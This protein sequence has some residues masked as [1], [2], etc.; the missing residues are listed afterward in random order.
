MRFT[1]KKKNYSWLNVWAFGFMWYINNTYKVELSWI[2]KGHRKLLLLFDWPASTG[3]KYLCTVLSIF[4][5]FTP[6]RDSSRQMSKY[7]TDE[8]EPTQK[9]RLQTGL[10]ILSGISGTTT[11]WNPWARSWEPQTGLSGLTRCCFECKHEICWL[12]WTEDFPRSAEK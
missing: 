5:H 8:R 1:E 4:S 9:S 11:W 2:Y 6:L 10:S 3:G 7:Q 12:F